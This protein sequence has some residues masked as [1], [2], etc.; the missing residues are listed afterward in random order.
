MGIFDVFRQKPIK[1]KEV[2]KPAL[3]YAP[4]Q[5]NIVESFK[6]EIELKQTYGFYQPEKYCDIVASQQ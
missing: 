6:G 2:L 4:E 3:I 5:I 1:I